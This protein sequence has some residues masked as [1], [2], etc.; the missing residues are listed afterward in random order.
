MKR[1]Q[2]L[3]DEALQHVPEIMPWDLP[4]R[5]QSRPSPLLLDVREPDEYAA[6]HI[7]GSILVPRGVLESACEWGFDDT[8]PELAAGRERPIIVVCRSGKRS[9]LAGRT[10][11]LLGFAD[12]TSL[13]LG[14][15]GWNDDGQPLVDADGNEVDPDTADDFFRSQVSEAQMGPQP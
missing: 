10:L 1:L 5:L 4:E 12:V 9:A 6:M 15:R 13:K 8:V 14:L 11:Q 3:I 2:D 7:D